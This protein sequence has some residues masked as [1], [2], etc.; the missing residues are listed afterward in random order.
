MF[1]NELKK[2]GIDLK[3]KESLIVNGVKPNVLQSLAM[4]KNISYTKGFTAAQDV[5]R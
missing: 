4:S 5:K 2:H 1:M 3:D